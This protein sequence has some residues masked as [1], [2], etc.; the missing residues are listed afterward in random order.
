MKDNSKKPS[1]SPQTAQPGSDVLDNAMER[2]KYV[3]ELVNHWI[4]NAD[5]K[6]SIS[7]GIFVGVFGVITFLA[8]RYIRPPDDAVINCCFRCIYRVGFF[9]SLACMLAAVFS[10]ARA[11]IPNL[12]SSGTQKPTQKTYPIYFGDIQSFELDKY[13]KLMERGTVK[14]F[15]DELATESWHNSKVC[16]KKMKWYRVGVIFSGFAL[17]FALQ[18]FL[19]HFLMYR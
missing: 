12:K 7:C 2:N 15:N 13:K 3:Y 8:E 16:M 19:A 11:I 18:S 1:A 17:A 10:Y 5:N 4:E 14:A 6:V 9:C